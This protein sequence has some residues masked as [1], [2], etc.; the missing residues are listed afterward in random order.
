MV[1]NG[2]VPS[3]VPRGSVLK[4]GRLYYEATADASPFDARWRQVG[5][6]GNLVTPSGVRRTPGMPAGEYRKSSP[7]GD[8]RALILNIRYS[9]YRDADRV[10][11]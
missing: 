7:G 6:H 8:Q 11:S 10:F 5:N 1:A 4:L 3:S 2:R 9:E